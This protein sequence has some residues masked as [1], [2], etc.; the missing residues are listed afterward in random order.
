VPF[1]GILHEILP[2]ALPAFVLVLL[3]AVV[4]ALWNFI[5]KRTAGDV[6][7]FWLGLCF[8]GALLAPVAL[9]LGELPD[10][11]GLPYI[12]ATGV[13]HAF[14]FALL[15]GSYKHGEMSVVYPLARGT[16]VAGTAAVAF[17]LLDEPIS[18]VGAVGLSCV[19]GGIV[20]IGLRELLARA[21]VHSCLLAI[22]VG[23]ATTAY[24][25]VD[26]LGVTHVAPLAYIA[27]LASFAALFLAPY[28][29]WR[30]RGQ[31]FDAWRSR[32][33]A[34]LGIGLGSMLT[35]LI[36][37]YAFRLANVSYVVAV[38]EV[39]IV[40]VALLSVTVLK[41]AMTVQRGLAIGAILTGV[42]LVKLA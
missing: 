17:L 1:I 11:A 28:V 8:A 21:D 26:K 31:C 18:L 9:L 23:V 13:I 19:C 35:Y 29:L 12:L 6:G 16:G 5:A 37:V 33:A 32:K 24:S 36:I 14:Y 40:V 27:G 20:M 41:E 7:V 10:A 30:F 34:S 3:A 38:R 39:S 15:A 2:L 42:I 22:L 25:I 4:H